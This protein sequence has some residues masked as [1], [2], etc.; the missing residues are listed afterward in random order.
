MNLIVAPFGI[1]SCDVYYDHCH[2]W[3][4][5][6]THRVHRSY[7]ILKTLV[8]YGYWATGA[9]VSW[10]FVHGSLLG[11]LIVVNVL[12]CG[13]VGGTCVVCLGCQLWVSNLMRVS[14]SAGL[15]EFA[16]FRQQ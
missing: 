14:K 1:K 5:Y 3:T 15:V 4:G 2:V 16:R 6:P 13:C 9:Y 12:C 8:K 11:G 10:K 7:A